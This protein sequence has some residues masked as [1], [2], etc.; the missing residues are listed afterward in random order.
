MRDFS[1]EL[2]GLRRRL[3]EAAGYLDLEGRRKRLA[4]LEA[5]VSR[6]DLW[7]DTSVGQQVTREYGRIKGDVEE[8][9]G[10]DS[11]VSDAE[12]L[13]QLAVEEDDSS[14]AAELEGLVAVLERE[15]ADL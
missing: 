5:E 14:V 11:R 2:R 9:E 7:D 13:Y 1:D 15:L 6:P 4:E 10:L 12:T 3:T 8:M